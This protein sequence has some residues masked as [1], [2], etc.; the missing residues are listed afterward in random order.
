[1]ALAPLPHIDVELTAQQPLDNRI[2]SLPSTIEDEG[3]SSSGAVD[4]GVAHWDE[5]A[6][7]FDDEVFDAV[8]ESS[9]RC[10]LIEIERAAAKRDAVRAALVG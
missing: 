4:P 3:L 10:T 8:R 2:T 1:M 5:L 7:R 9:N 6:P